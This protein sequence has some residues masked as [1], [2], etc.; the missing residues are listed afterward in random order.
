MTKTL[1]I[2]NRSQLFINN[3]LSSLPFIEFKYTT[4]SFAFLI[5]YF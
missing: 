2:D 4:V 1:S 5:E 3:K